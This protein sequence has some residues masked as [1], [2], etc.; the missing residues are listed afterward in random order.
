MSEPGAAAEPTDE[1]RPISVLYVE[2]NQQTGPLVSEWL[3]RHDP[4][5]EVALAVTLDDAADRLAT[6]SFDAIVADYRFPGGKGLDLV[7][8]A[9]EQH[10]DLPFLLYSARVNDEVKEEADDVGVTAVVEKGGSE[11]LSK[12]AAYIV[13]DVETRVESAATAEADA[14]DDRL[15][16][17]ADELVHELRGPLSVALGHLDLLE[18]DDERTAKLEAALADMEAIIDELPDR[19]SSF[20][21]EED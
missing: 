9:R 2:D 20:E 15:E 7:S 4:R 17:F 10:G 18:A 1:T 14:G 6:E 19:A 3:E 11:Q 13:E 21:P 16:A 8:T 12:L 5:F